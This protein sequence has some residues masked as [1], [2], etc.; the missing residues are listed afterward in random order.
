MRLIGFH[1]FSHGSLRHFIL[2]F[3]KLS[4]TFFNQFHFFILQFYHHLLQPIIFLHIEIEVMHYGLEI[5]PDFLNKV[6][7][8]LKGSLDSITFTF[9]EN[10]N[11]ERESLLVV[12]RQN[13][14]GLCRQTF[15]NTPQ[16]NFHARNLNFHSM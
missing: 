16:A 12:I 7:K 4:L 10:S 6:K 8:I 14:A 13:I 15:E 2:S 1:H 5:R 3:L 9:S 11:Y